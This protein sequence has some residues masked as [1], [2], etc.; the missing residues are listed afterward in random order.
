MASTQPT[1]PQLHT[2]EVFPAP[3]S[4]ASGFQGHFRGSAT[5]AEGYQY[6]VGCSS[7]RQT[8]RASWGRGNHRGVSSATALQGPRPYLHPGKGMLFL[9]LKLWENL[10]LFLKL[11]DSVA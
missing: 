11:N 2:G 3:E 1:A 4:S 5:E 7:C 8:A 10:H 9:E 6:F